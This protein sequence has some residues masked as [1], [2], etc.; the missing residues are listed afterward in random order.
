MYY[1]I[2]N[3]KCVMYYIEYNIKNMYTYI[4]IFAILYC[5][6][7]SFFLSPITHATL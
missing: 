6:G 3:R 4:C 5:M 2:H 1:I 7:D